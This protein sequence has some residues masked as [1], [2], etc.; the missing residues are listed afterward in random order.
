MPM[1]GQL[2]PTMAPAA[3]NAGPI[4]V[5]QGN[6][7]NTAQAM[8]LIRNAV[9]MMQKALPMIPMGSPLHADLLTALPKISKHMEEGQQNKGVD[10]QSLLQMARQSSQQSP[11]AALNRL[12]PGGNTPP[13]MPTPPAGAAPPAAA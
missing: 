13:A 9:E 1:P 2:P 12:H 3:A 10:L 5:P 4:A 6:Q 11:M 7:G 8:S